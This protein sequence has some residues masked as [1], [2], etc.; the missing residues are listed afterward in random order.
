[1]TGHDLKAWKFFRVLKTDEI[2]T[3]YIVAVREEDLEQYEEW[4]VP[5][6]IQ[7]YVGSRNSK[8]VSVLPSVDEPEYDVTP[9]VEGDWDD[10]DSREA[11]E[12]LMA[13]L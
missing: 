13:R 4:Y 10:P 3:E 2:V 7:G 9:L 8:V 1:M 11:V 6:V 12:A 5:Q